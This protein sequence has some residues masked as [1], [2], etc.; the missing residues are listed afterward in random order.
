MAALRRLPPPKPGNDARPLP[1]P[2]ILDLSNKLHGCKFFSCIDLVKGYHQI[3]MAAQ[4]IAKTAIIT[5]FGLFEYLFMPF[6]LRNAAQTFQRFM[7]SLFKHL[8]LVFCYL[9]DLI[10]ASDT[11][12]EHH[13]HLRQIFTIL[14][15]ND[16]QINPASACL[17]PPPWSSWATGWTSMASGRSSCTYRPLVIF[18]PLRM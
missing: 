13:K 18:L 2:S 16:L 8:P 1:P 11:L 7:D 4:D 12:E 14:Q 3:P 5:P 15:E 17:P 10:I 6:G 9:D